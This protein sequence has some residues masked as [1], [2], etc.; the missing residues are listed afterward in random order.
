MGNGRAHWGRGEFIGELESS[1]GMRAHWE[2]ESSLGKGRAHLEGESSLGRRELIGEGGAHWG[3]R[4]LIWDGDSLLGNGR[5]HWGMGKL[6]GKESSL[7][8]ERVRRKLKSFWE[9]GELTENSWGWGRLEWK[10]KSHGW[11]GN[12]S[13]GG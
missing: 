12:C 9:R 3:K 5:A 8:K 6:I 10:G 1:L 2:G 4:E 13:W 11:K 7:G